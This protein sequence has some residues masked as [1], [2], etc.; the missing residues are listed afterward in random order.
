VFTLYA[1]DTTLDL[2]P[3]ATKA[4]LLQAM[5]GHILEEATTVGT[6]GR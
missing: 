6:Y 3:G 4:A 1:L 2:P 5:E